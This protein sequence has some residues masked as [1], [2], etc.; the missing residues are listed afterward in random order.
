MDVLVAG[1]PAGAAG[2]PA[3]VEA[4]VQVAEVRVAPVVVFQA[5]GAGAFLVAAAP[6]GA[7]AAEVA[8][9]VARGERCISRRWC[10]WFPQSTARRRVASACS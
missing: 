8:E 9:A 6:V 4:V 2:A 1:A 10:A 3:V 7:G 5:E